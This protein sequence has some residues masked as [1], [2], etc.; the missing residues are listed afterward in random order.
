[1]PTLRDLAGRLGLG[2]ATVSRAL[3]GEKRVAPETHARVLAAAKESGY[4]PNAL[5]NAL[6]AQVRQRHRLKPTGEVVA[7]LTSHETENAW[8][9]Y[10]LHMQQFESARNRAWQ[11]GFDLQP[12]WLGEDG[13]RSRQMA[14]VLQARGVRGLM[15]VPLTGK[16]C[17]LEIDWHDYAVVATGYTFRQA[18]VHRVVHD[19]IGLVFSCY[20]QLR[21]AGCQR[22]GLAMRP[23]DNDRLQ[24]RWITGF[25]GAQNAYGGARLAPCW[26]PDYENPGPFRRWFRRSRPDAVIGIW[27]DVPLAWLRGNCDVRVPEDVCYATLDVGN[28]VGK[29]AGMLQD[30]HGAGTAAMDLLVGQLFR[31]EIGLPPKPLRILIEG[32][33]VHGPTARAC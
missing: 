30:N 6:M 24:L 26:F 23:I 25:L 29:S 22:I 8:R 1:M 9:Q 4:R 28:R 31:N 27:P 16:Q 20:E 12:L 21:K 14:R 10:P 33:W 5:V 15:L 13:A 7:F 3:R 19:N 2:L 32:T 17:S 18:A 11:L